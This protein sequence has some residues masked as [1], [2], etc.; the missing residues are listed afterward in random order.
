MDEHVDYNLSAKY[1][2]SCKKEGA[3]TAL[4]SPLRFKSEVWGPMLCFP[5]SLLISDKSSLRSQF[6]GIH[7]VAEQVA[8]IAGHISMQCCDLNL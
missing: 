4:S 8:S 1:R 6:H 7:L 2:S 5:F 3:Q